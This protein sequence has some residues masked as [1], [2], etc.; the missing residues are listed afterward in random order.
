MQDMI[1]LFM[2]VSAIAAS[3]VFGVFAA[4]ALCR[5]AF[6]V[7]RLHSTAVANSRLAK[8]EATS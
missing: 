8:A 2:L 5:T 1:N 3:L 7:L 6:T 4:H